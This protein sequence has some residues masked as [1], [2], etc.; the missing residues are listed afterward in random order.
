MLRIICIHQHNPPDCFSVLLFWDAL[1]WTTQTA[2]LKN[3]SLAA[4][5]TGIT[6]RVRSPEHSRLQINQN[7]EVPD[8][9]VAPAELCTKKGAKTG[10]TLAH[11]TSALQDWQ[12]SSQVLYLV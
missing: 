7:S 4:F 12:W 8:F 11:G 5:L 3:N 6:D 9:I 1:D 2:L 10:L